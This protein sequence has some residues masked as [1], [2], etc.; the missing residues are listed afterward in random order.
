M[1]SCQRSPRLQAASGSERKETVNNRVDSPVVM[2]LFIHYLSE[3][4][5]EYIFRFLFVFFIELIIFNSF[6]FLFF[7]F[8]NKEP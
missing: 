4:I 3:M 6:G 1:L 7:F 2:L 5:H 8:L